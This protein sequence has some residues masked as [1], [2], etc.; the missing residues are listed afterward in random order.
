MHKIKVSIITVTY[1]AGEANLTKTITSVLSQTIFNY[2]YIIIDGCSC[3]QDI[4][5]INNL[6]YGHDNIV[7]ISEPDQGIYDAMNKGVKYA[8]G[9]WIIFM[10]AGDSFY[11]SQTLASVFRTSNNLI[12]Y[13]GVF[14]NTIRIYENGKKLLVKGKDLSNIEYDLLLPFCHQS[15]FMKKELLQEFPFNINYKQAADYDFFIKMFLHNKKL[16]YIDLVISNYLMG[17]ISEKQNIIQFKEK[18]KIR[19]ENGLLQ[20]SS[21]FIHKKLFE[22]KL[23]KVLKIFIPKKIIEKIK[24]YK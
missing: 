10:N 21:F 22:L 11:S 18:I 1:N 5:V 3:E 24:G 6:I 17:G 12:G 19:E 15:V 23:K 9:E 13:D 2:E 8:S 20:Y 14:G 4:Q 7:F 16:F